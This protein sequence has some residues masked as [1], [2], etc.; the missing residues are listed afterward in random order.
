MDQVRKAGIVLV[1]VMVLV[2]GL[3]SVAPAAI[4]VEG[5]TYVGVF[6]KYLWRG[7][8]LSGSQPVAQGGVDLSAGGFTLSYWSNLQM[9]NDAGDGYSAGEMNETDLIIDYSF[10]VNE[11]VSLSI[12]NAFYAVEGIDDT[13]EAYLTVALNTFLSPSLTAYWDWD[14]AKQSGLFYILSIGHDIELSE[15]LTLSLSASCGYN[16]ESDFLI[17]DYNNWHNAEFGVGIDYALTDQ[18]TLSPSFL[19]STPISDDA[20]NI[21]GIDDEMTAGLNITFSF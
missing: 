21:A 17:G 2:V 3:V 4:E 14:K 16:Q 9:F 18:L 1:F 13:N 12:G 7:F 11:Q 20:E 10:D 19:Y 15:Q 6:D 8:D 5:D